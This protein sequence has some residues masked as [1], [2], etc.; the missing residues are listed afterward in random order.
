LIRHVLGAFRAGQIKADA[1]A[2]KLGLSRSRFYEL[3]SDYL[4]ACAHHRQAAWTPAVS[5]GD[6][7]PEWPAPVQALLR[8]R[9]SS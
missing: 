2:Q 9:L 6:H 3:Y 8:K 7:A 5:G 4:K 1:A